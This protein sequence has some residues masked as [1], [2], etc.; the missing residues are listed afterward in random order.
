MYS[1]ISNNIIKTLFLRHTEIQLLTLWYFHIPKIHE[2]PNNGSKKRDFINCLYGY[3]CSLPPYILVA[4]SF[5]FC[6]TCF[7][8][9][10]LK[11]W[12]NHGSVLPTSS[13]LWRNI[14]SKVGKN[15]FPSTH[16]R[17]L[18]KSSKM[19]WA[20]IPA[21]IPTIH[22]QSV[23]CAY[24]REMLFFSPD[25]SENHALLINSNPRN[26]WKQMD[27]VGMLIYHILASTIQ[28]C[29]HW[30]WPK[31]SNGNQWKTHFWSWNG[32]LTISHF[33]QPSPRARQH[34]EGQALCPADLV[35][36]QRPVQYP[37]P[38]G[39]E[40]GIIVLKW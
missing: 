26:R 4:Q 3:N 15:I 20:T 37:A 33:F 32:C 19:F 25:M 1:L 34:F 2:N 6:W 18:V 11:T 31:S 12:R 14:P 40:V 10:Q 21:K 39:G 28:Y 35:D 8:R 30:Y 29:D 5:S 23:A 17:I 7:G 9:T 24:I 16:A 27:F 13:S 22:P 38:D 36:G